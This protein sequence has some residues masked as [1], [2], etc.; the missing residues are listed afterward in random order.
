MKRSLREVLAE[1]HVA[2]VT[3]AVFLFW[4]ADSVVQALWTP[5]SKVAVYLFTAVAIFDIPYFSYPLNG[6]DRSSLILATLY[7]LFAAFNFAAA[8]ILSRWAYGVG[9]LRSLGQ[10]RTKLPR[11]N[12]V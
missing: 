12:N 10:Y 4:S 8:W 7:L 3:I 11:R 6:G 5:V 1:S 9:P 2:A